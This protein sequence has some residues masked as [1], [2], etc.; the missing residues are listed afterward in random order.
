M[1]MDRRLLL[2]LSM[3]VGLGLIAVYGASSYDALVNGS[4]SEMG[5]FMGHL[6][7]VG[8]AVLAFLVM[9]VVPYR[10]SCRLALY[11]YPVTV[12][13]LLLTV[14]GELGIG[15]ANVFR[16]LPFI[17]GTTLQPVELTK[18]CL[19]LGIPYWIDRHPESTQKLRGGFLTLFSIPLV[20]MLV[21][22]AQPNFG[23]ILALGL[24]CMCIFWLAGTRASYLSTLVLSGAFFGLMG[25][26]HVG[27]IH[28]RVNAWWAVL[29]NNEVVS[30][31]G[32][33]SYQALVGLGAG[34]L[35]GVGPGESTMK[36]LFLP[37]SH[38]DFILAILGEELGFLGAGALLLVIGLLLAR[39]MKIAY[40]SEDGL[41]YLAC[42]GVTSMIFSYTIVNVA[43]VVSLM[44]VAGL[45][46]PFVSYGGWALMTN[47]AAMGVVVNVSR[48]L[49]ERR[50]PADRW[51]GV[52]L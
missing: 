40:H 41:A 39:T 24:M 45:P 8:L 42:L 52:P 31:Y 18:L 16:W 26:Q 15:N 25:Y 50:G 6:N 49:R 9:L 21:L 12:V 5:V 43:M 38:T 47:M 1:I 4:G 3:L 2:F 17:G 46:L 34:G 14:V 30:D 10:V 37:A 7:K 20:A 11:A 23:S 48:T 22:A 33:Q 29:R 36:F 19:A 44:P 27:K 51:V 28:E 13:L 32:Y 35:H